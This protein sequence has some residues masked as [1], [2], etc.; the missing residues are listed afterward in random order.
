MNFIR[1]NIIYIFIYIYIYMYIFIIL[2]II[3]IITIIKMYT[4]PIEADSAIKKFKPT[5][6]INFEMKL[7]YEYL[8]IYIIL[9]CIIITITYTDPIEADS[10][11]KKFKPT[12]A[13]FLL[14]TNYHH[15]HN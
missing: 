6:I 8:H 4:D 9:T 12:I 13:Q 11:I 14:Y 15:Y 10:A 1:E 7:M 2:I 5:T 3:I